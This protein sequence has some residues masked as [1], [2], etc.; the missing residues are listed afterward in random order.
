M[1]FLADGLE[2]AVSVEVVVEL[3]APGL[4]ILAV[5]FLDVVELAPD[6][7]LLGGGDRRPGRRGGA[8][9]HQGR[10]GRGARDAR[11]APIGYDLTCSS[12]AATNSGFT[13][14]RQSL[15]TYSNGISFAPPSD[16]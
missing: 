14:L 10:R 2:M 8:G 13:K 6:V 1:V 5:L 16:V 9:S 4:A 3:G 11:C 12:I 15:R 7:Q